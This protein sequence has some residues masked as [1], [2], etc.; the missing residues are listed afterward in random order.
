REVRPPLLGRLLLCLLPRRTRRLVRDDL[1]EEFREI[2]ESRGPGGARRWYLDYAVRSLWDAWLGPR[3]TVPRDRD[4]GTGLLADWVGDIKH[5]FRLLRREPVVSFA[6]VGTMVLA[7]GAISAAASLVYGVLVRPLPYP[8]SGRI[9]Q[10]SR[11][12][13]RTPPPWRAVGL[14]DMRAWR[15]ESTSMAEVAGWTTTGATLVRDDGPE[16]IVIEPEPVAPR[17]VLE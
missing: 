16:R 11:T 17:V 2:V 14:P 5:G 4:S 1:E 3:G 12:E 10:I 7:I 8:D 13:G 15:K 6:M 9:V